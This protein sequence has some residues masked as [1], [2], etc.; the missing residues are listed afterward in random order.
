MK[1]KESYIK[2]APVIGN[3]FINQGFERVKHLTRPEK[4]KEEMLARKIYM[5][6][7]KKNN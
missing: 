4:L 5:K 3:N 1:I 7:Q 6:T 2:D